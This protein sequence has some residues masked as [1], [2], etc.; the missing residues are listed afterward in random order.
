MKAMAYRKT[1]STRNSLYCHKT[2]LSYLNVH[3]SYTISINGIKIVCF[4]YNNLPAEPYIIM[5]VLCEWSPTVCYVGDWVNSLILTYEIYPTGYC[6]W[7]YASLSI[8]LGR[9]NRD[10]KRLFHVCR[11]WI[12]AA[13]GSYSLHDLYYKNI[14]QLHQLSS[15]MYS[16]RN[17]YGKTSSI[18]RQIDLLKY[19]SKSETLLKNF[20]DQ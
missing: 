7:C 14:S 20:Q 1:F 13:H 10:L 2:F 12:M 19:T 18:P 6:A 5:K 15:Y 9:L 16:F 4:F 3:A 17:N 8:K 11:K